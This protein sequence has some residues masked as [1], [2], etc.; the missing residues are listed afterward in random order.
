LSRKIY[1][2]S[3]RDLLT[4]AAMVFTGTVLS[5]CCVPHNRNPLRAGQLLTPGID[6]A[7]TPL[8]ID[9]HC[10]I[11][12]ASDLQAVPFISKVL[13]NEKGIAEVVVEALAEI[14]EFVAWEKAPNGAMELLALQR[15]SALK[16]ENQRT[17][18]YQAYQQEGYE[19][20]Q[21]A[22]LQSR[23]HIALSSAET[24]MSKLL[25]T[26]PTKEDVLRQIYASFEPKS[27]SDHIAKRTKDLKAVQEFDHSL[28][29]HGL[30]TAAT[31]STVAISYSIQGIIAYLSQCFQYR[32]VSAQDY[33]D[34]FTPA[35]KRSVD[36]MLPSLVDYDWWLARGKSTPTP[37][38]VQVKVMEQISILSHGQVHGFVPFDP[39]REVAHRANKDPKAYSSLKLVHDAVLMSGCIGVKLYPPM[40]FA[41]YGN[42]EIDAKDPSF[43]EQDYLPD[44]LHEPIYYAC[45]GKSLK[46]G[47]RLDEVLDEL[48]AWCCS[49]GV[50]IMAHSN[51]TN[52]V[53]DQ[54]KE[55]ANACYWSKALVKH[56]SLRINFGH[57]GDFSASEDDEKN[58]IPS[59]TIPYSAEA[60]IKLFSKFNEQDKTSGS[61][62]YGDSAYDA[63]ILK[64][65]TFL[66]KRYKAALT[67]PGNELLPSRLMFGTDWDLLMA[68]GDVKEYLEEFVDLFVKLD[69]PNLDDGRTQS[70]HFFGWNAVDYLGL[71]IGQ[72]ART[73]LEKFYGDNNI[74]IKTNPPVW[75]AKIDPTKTVRVQER[76]SRKR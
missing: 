45:D 17:V 69:L 11:F 25:H 54:Y 76:K 58:P 15:L 2:S 42:A 1:L 68:L 72:P 40:G 6:P 29:A 56:P 41:P 19:S 75:M 35:A 61:R 50:P 23:S 38:D 62:G 33:L 28:R 20:A 16:S 44:W 53:L 70:E 43:W 26:T 22:V 57:L 59:E 52:G 3:R 4:N 18:M 63:E 27:Y 66:L 48:Y 21:G 5:G 37:L 73:R 71:G 32:Y 8:T 31:S 51:A 64:D 67:T 39:L 10:H 24:P 14:V 30:L 74:D 47:V 55:L 46:L 36:M 34:T 65:E 13:A 60:F 7:T 12:N 9:T 49:N